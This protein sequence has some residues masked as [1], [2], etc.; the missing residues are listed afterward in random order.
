MRP[1]C[2]RCGRDLPAE[3]PGRVH[4]HASNAPSAPTAPTAA[5]RALPQLRRRAR[6][7]PDP[8]RR[9]CSPSIPPRPAAQGAAVSAPPRILI[10]AGSDSRGG[11][12]IQADIKTVTMLGGYAMTAITAVTAQNTLGVDGGRCRC[13]PRWSLAQIDAVRRRHRRRCG[14]DRHDRLGRDRRRRSPTGWSGCAGADRVRSGDG[15]D[16]RRGA[17]R[18][19]DDRRRSSG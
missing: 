11:A 6:A 7:A 2:E 13:R 14:E 12:G 10:I 9:S 1:D 16:Q 15:R 3:A 8:R 5:R 19:G 4:L 17:G 18:R